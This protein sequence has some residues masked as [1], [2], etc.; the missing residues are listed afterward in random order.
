MPVY[1]ARAGSAGPVKIGHARDPKRRMTLLQTGNP[2][3]L[4]VIRLIAGGLPEEAE[5]HR[6]FADLRLNGEWFTFA[7]E[8]LTYGVETVAFNAARKRGPT[9]QFH[10]I[11]Q[12][13]V[14]KGG[15][16]EQVL[17]AWRR[18]GVP[19]RVCCRAYGI[20]V[21]RG[22]DPHELEDMAVFRRIIRP[23]VAA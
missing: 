23:E 19:Y 13:I 6:H 8:M 10:P 1:F 22:G 11:I 2:E 7:E 3:R 14:A 9:A 5:A 20:A 18:R 4:A 21:E 16:S 15:F 17:T 12:E